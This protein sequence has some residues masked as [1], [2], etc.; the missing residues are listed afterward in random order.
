MKIVLERVKKDYL[1]KVLA[2]SL[3]GNDYSTVIFRASYCLDDIKDTIDSLKDEF[4]L[5]NIIYIDFDNDKI[6]QFYESNPT[7]KEIENFITKLPK[8]TGNI[9]V[10]YIC[11]TVTDFSDYKYSE[12]YKKYQ[13]D[14]KKYN[15]DIFDK[16]RS[17]PRHNITSTIIPNKEWAESLIGDQNELKELWIK[18]NKTLLNKDEAKKEIEERIERKNELN[19]MR[20]KNLTFHTNLGTDFKIALNPHS[21]WRSEPNNLDAGYNMLNYPS[22]EIY[23]SPNCYSAEGIIVL[24]KRRRFYYNTMIEDATF[25]F[26]KG[27]LIK[28]ESNNKSSDKI[29]L[30]KS[31]KMNRIGEIALVPNSSPLAVEND[32]YDNI[33]LDENTGCHFALGD[34][35]KECI[36]VEKEKLEEYGPRNYRYNTSKYHSDFVFGD[37]SISVEAETKGKK[38]VLLMENG[39]WKI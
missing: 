21:I 37:K 33:I 14:L 19:R 15:Q 25:E 35:I 23:T 9:K 24:S 20:I 5:D 12:H 11:N 32:F 22:Y 26:S 1:R 8:A 10:I 3:N 28:C 38:K 36:G 18:I 17:L 16:M 31:N 7:E 27:L 29:V 6:Q 2:T 4:N 34:S 30:K 13:S 39:E